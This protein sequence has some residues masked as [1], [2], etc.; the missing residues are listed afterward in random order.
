LDLDNE[1]KKLGVALSQEA[2]QNLEKIISQINQI[3]AGTHLAVPIQD[4]EIKKQTK[5]R[6]ALKKEQTTSTKRNALA[7]EIVEEKLKKD[8]LAKKRALNA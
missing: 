5:G 4:P 8:Q 1:L 7:F 2:P 3:V 6:P